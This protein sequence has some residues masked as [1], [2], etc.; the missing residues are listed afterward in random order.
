MKK[1]KK[2]KHFLKKNENFSLIFHFQ[3]HYC[4]PGT[5]LSE[6][7]SLDDQGINILDKAC[8]LHD[9][10][11]TKYPSGDQRQ[12][13]D[14]ILATQARMRSFS[15]NATIGERYTAKAVA[16]SMLGKFLFGA[17]SQNH[18]LHNSTAP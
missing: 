12:R 16:Y 11:Y 9:I 18:G 5:K 10:A 7:L 14:A 6:R 1:K 8:K 15:R 17:R 13:A 3:Y 4:G 2:M